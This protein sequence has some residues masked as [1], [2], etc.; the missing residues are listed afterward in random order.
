[1]KRKRSRDI[2]TTRTRKKRTRTSRAAKI[3]ESNRY[4]LLISAKRNG[5]LGA[6][7]R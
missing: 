7:E 1:M 5:K 3:R 6:A 2:V 4:A